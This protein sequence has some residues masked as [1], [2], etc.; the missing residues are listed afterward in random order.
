MPYYLPPRDECEEGLIVYPLG[1]PHLAGRIVKVHSGDDNQF[2]YVDVLWYG[3]STETTCFCHNLR[4][5]EEMAK[6]AIE[7]A[8]KFQETLEAM[9]VDQED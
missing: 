6:D 2:Y 4:N 3:K 7:K 9:Y 8:S 1:N 5:F